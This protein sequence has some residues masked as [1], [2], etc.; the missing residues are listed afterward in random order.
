[1]NLR[2]LKKMIAEEYRYWMAEQPTPGEMPG[3]M[4]GGMPGAGGAA[5]DAPMDDL[6]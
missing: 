1:M 6:D 3:G 5:P 2:E 4:P